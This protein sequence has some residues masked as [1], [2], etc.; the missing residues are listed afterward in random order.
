M[1]RFFLVLTALTLGVGCSK[2]N[3][4]TANGKE[5][6]TTTKTN[7]IKNDLQ[8]ENLKG[9][10]KWVKLTEYEGVEN[11]GKIEK[12]IPIEKKEV[13]LKTYD[14][15]GYLI[16]FSGDNTDRHY[17]YRSYAL[18]FLQFFFKKR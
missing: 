12:K 3:D 8:R 13:C 15:E 18:P 10:V 11:N 16:Q 4:E 17:G 5:T 6:A 1:K 2:N 9:K 7:G 14:K